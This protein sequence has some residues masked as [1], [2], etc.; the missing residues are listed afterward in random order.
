[1]LKAARH[2]WRQQQAPPPPTTMTEQQQEG[3]SSQT[4]QHAPA[5]APGFEAGA[6]AGPELAAIGEAPAAATAAAPQPAEAAAPAAPAAAGPLLLF[7]DTS[8]LLPMLGAGA[9][10]CIPTFFTLDLLGSLA[11]QGRFGRGLQ[12]SEQVSMLWHVVHVGQWQRLLLA[13]SAP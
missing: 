8:A 11:R 5:A 13:G 4:A 10:V 9:N 2:S 12:F 6:E 1:V 3:I 7:P